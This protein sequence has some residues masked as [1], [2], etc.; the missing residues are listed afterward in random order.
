MDNSNIHTDENARGDKPD[1]TKDAARS[2]K[3]FKTGHKI[4][5]A[6]LFVTAI[7]GFKTELFGLTKSDPCKTLR[8]REELVSERIE[9]LKRSK[10][11]S[12][13]EDFNERYYEFEITYANAELRNIQDSLKLMLCKD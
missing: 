6:A 12:T 7:I 1:Q 8:K 4:A 11:K 5:I 2:K 10:E 9:D 3:R 13:N